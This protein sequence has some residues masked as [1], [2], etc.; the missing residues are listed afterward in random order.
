MKPI[1]YMMIILVGAAAVLCTAAFLSRSST[2][3]HQSLICDEDV[4]NTIQ[5]KKIGASFIYYDEANKT[6]LFRSGPNV[7]ASYQPEQN[8]FCEIIKHIGPVV[9]RNTL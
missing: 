9:E 7:I 4:I 3:E 5:Y 6:Y 8:E 1:T 2:L